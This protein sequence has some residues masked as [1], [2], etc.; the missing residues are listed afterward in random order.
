MKIRILAALVL[1]SVSLAQAQLSL[2]P[3]DA[4]VAPAFSDQTAPAIARGSNSTLVVWADN[5]TNPDGPYTWSE[6][7]TSRDIYG[8]RLDAAGNVIDPVPISI[9]A[10]RSIQH[11][12]KVSWNGS[13]WLVV[14]KSVDV[15]GTGYYY[16]D[17]LEA[18]RV[19]P[20]GQVLDAKP[21]KLHGLTPS[22][23]DW[24]VGSDGN[25]WV[26]V[27]QGTSAGGD[28]VAIR[29]SPAG[30][31]LDPLNRA[32]VSATYYMRSNFR[33]AYA[34]GVF[35]LTF[36]DGGAYDTKA[37]RFDSNLDKLDAQPISLLPTSL[38]ALAGSDSGFYAVWNRQEPDFSVHVVGSRVSTA[39]VML[40]G[41]GANLSGTKEPYY[42][43]ITAVTWDGVNWRVTWGEYAMT[44]V[45]RVTSAGV[46]LDPG[47]V[48]VPGVPTGP[49]AGNGAG[50]LQ[51]VW[52]MYTNGAYGDYDVFAVKIS[53]TN[54][55]GPSQTLSV[56]A[57][58]QLRPD[59]ATSGDGS[60]LVYRS[61]ANLISRVVAQ[62]FDAAGNPLTPEPVQLDAG[63]SLAN[64]M[65]GPSV[66]WNGSVYLVSWY[67]VGGI[68]AQR[69]SA[70]GAK[71]DAAPFM[72]MSGCFGPTDA[73]ALGNDFFVTGRKVG[74]SIQY[75]G[76]VGAR[77]SGAGAVLDASPLFL[78]IS[79]VG[80]APAV[81]ALGGRWLVAWH[82]NAT[83]SSSS[84]FSMGAFVD[85]GG[86][87]TPEFQ[88]HGPF[89]TA[90]G[91]GIFEVGLAS[92]GNTVLF[93]Q[94]QEITSGVENDLLCHV[95]DATGT[96]GPQINLT[97]WS[98]NQYRPRVAW[99]GS[100]FVV[101]YQDQ[102][103]R[104]ALW[105]LDQLDARSDLYAMRV[106]PSGAII[107]PQGFVFSARPNAETDPTVAAFNGTLFLAGA[108][109]ENDD[110]YA[111][112]RIAYDLLPGNGPVAVINASATEGDV[113]LAVNFT[114]TGSTGVSSAWDFGDGGTSSVANPSHTFTVAGEYLVSLTVTDATGSQ[115]TQAQMINATNP[116]QIPVAIATA[117]SYAGVLP[118]DVIFY[119]AGSYDPDGFIGNI[120]W[121]F[122]DG[123]S[124]WGATAYHTFYEPGPQTVTLNCY[125]GRGGVG[126]TNLIINASGV[127]LPPIAVAAAAPTS[128]GPPLNVQFNS[129]ASFDADGT[130][131]QYQWT[132]GDGS[133][134]TSNEPDPIHTYTSSGTY[135]ATLT[136]WDNDNESSSD[137]VNID[138]L[139]MHHVEYGLNLSL[140]PVYI[141]HYEQGEQP[142][143][144]IIRESVQAGYG[145]VAGEA[146]VGFGV[147]KARVDLAGTDPINPLWFE[148]G[149]A[150]SRYWDMFQFD[151]PQLNG[152]HGFFDVTLYVAGSGSVNLSDGYLLS[153]DT[154]FDAFWHAV[155]NVSV[156]GVN[157]PLGGPIQSLYY[158][159]QWYKD[160]DMTSLDYYG[161][162][163][164]TYQQ[165]ATLEFIYGQPIFMDS[166]LQVDTY[167]DNQIS[168]VAGTL[169]SVI[170]LG[171][172]SY[173]GGISNLRD[174]QGNPVSPAGYSSSSGFD[175]RQPAVPPLVLP[176]VAKGDG[177]IARNRSL[178]LL[179]LPQAGS[180]ALRVTLDSLH[181]V[182]PPYTGGQA[183][184]FSAFEGQVRWIGPPT[185]YVESTSGG[186]PF[187]ASQL[188]CT[189][190]YQ[191]WSTVG[192]LHVFGSAIVPS[193]LYRV[194]TVA[195]SCQGFE[196]NCTAVSAPLEVITGRWGDVEV[197]YNPPS[198]TAQPDLGDIAAL[199]H[200]FM[201]TPG[202]PIKARAL[203]A[204]SDRFGNIDISLDL[205]FSDIAV[206][207]DA[208]R[209]NSYPY[210]IATCP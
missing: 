166:F 137:T 26:V 146:N 118:L 149:F 58:Q 197:P 95:I 104:L 46:L 142:V 96:V 129:D 148:Y 177:G 88:I 79:Y 28:V 189:P 75:I 11:Y 192:L 14:F 127:N 180:T 68:F 53:P 94:S 109:M 163:L 25:N 76:P 103:N 151:D 85:A 32:L 23:N 130:I 178:S 115:T 81:V 125:D 17:S 48:A 135:I 91:N 71:L 93:V 200:K 62:P 3:G 196:G 141:E 6:Y 101:V 37:V 56:G 27:N 140:G 114:S 31:M 201:S 51:L 61:S 143:G 193:S 105:T 124:Y 100:N 64:G 87:V 90:G 153:P 209:G 18:V 5:R 179:T 126:T 77:V 168:S 92:S 187:Q 134:V 34:G 8:V 55:V 108:L 186:I 1:T 138:V 2:L 111:N 204:G 36:S 202:A 15:S 106:S 74:S 194:E 70:T 175:Y 16:Q 160:L 30:V 99:D 43:S 145:R 80:S 20:T 33:L 174:S 41:N 157:D 150:T 191:D 59:V 207:V 208:F 131:V 203:L 42:D 66:A 29:I 63:A 98:G 210:A 84:C 136:V 65:T 154:T 188:Q 19:S 120:E 184:D 35:L 113:P 170:D 195:S 199:A 44:Y 13:N 57:P 52:S 159:G 183:A 152:T 86:T 110:A 185:Q 156:E 164:N 47:S 128:G 205:D 117:N 22:G 97:P 54:V 161:D 123:G 165:T 83:H 132:F 45:A 7:E 60:M 72:V 50:G 121:L 190:Y 206:C 82:R 112:Y 10:A 173:W 167:F 67:G 158:A 172:S 49:I 181:H 39:G 119:A 176:S 24:T 21:I 122:S 89:S 182:S 139:V 9:V 147:N 40:D 102:K 4:T 78:G 69:L 144:P 133:G 107:D 116:N 171:N 73:A 12:P 162:P 38:N 169:D 198:P 155:I